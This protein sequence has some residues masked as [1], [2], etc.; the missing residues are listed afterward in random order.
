MEEQKDNRLSDL[1]ARHDDQ[2]MRQFWLIMLVVNLP[3][4]YWNDDDIPEV[5]EKYI[6]RFITKCAVNFALPLLFAWIFS[7]IRKEEKKDTGPTRISRLAY[8]VSY[9][10]CLLAVRYGAGHS[11]L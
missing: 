1:A 7:S 8:V 9:V 3:L 2:K 10:L 11:T 5:G 4:T 6:V